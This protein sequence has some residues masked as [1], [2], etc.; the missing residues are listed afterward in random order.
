VARVYEAAMAESGYG[1]PRAHAQKTQSPRLQKTTQSP[2]LQFK[3]EDPVKRESSRKAMAVTS[4]AP[5]PSPSPAPAS[6]PHT[7]SPKRTP[8]R[9]FKANIQKAPHS[10]SLSVPR[11]SCRR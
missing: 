11:A 4:P 3:P 6:S 7:P 5:A 10:V 2:R 1:S 8:S 9:K